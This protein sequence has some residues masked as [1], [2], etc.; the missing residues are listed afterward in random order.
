M[1]NMRGKSVV[2]HRNFH[3]GMNACCTYF[4]WPFMTRYIDEVFVFV[5]MCGW[6]LR[7]QKCARMDDG[8]NGVFLIFSLSSYPL[9]RPC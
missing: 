3:T 5:N 2:M 1:K 7:T 4:D 8:C 6:F 9:K